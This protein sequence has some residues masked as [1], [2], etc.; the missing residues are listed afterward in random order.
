M[1]YRFL[2]VHEMNDVIVALIGFID[3][4]TG[5]IVFFSNSW[6]LTSIKYILPLAFFYLCLGIWS[7]GTNV[8]NKNYY[9][10]RG[11]VD[12]ISAFCFASIYLGDVYSTFELFGI[13]ITLKGMLSIFLITTKE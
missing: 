3:I 8:L 12:L 6:D 4:I 9:D 1:P 5:I 7:L 11:I 10:W 13:I 2:K